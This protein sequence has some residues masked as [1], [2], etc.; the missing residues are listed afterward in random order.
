MKT[1]ILI[2]RQVFAI[3][4]LAVV[5]LSMNTGCSSSGDGDAVD[6]PATIPDVLNYEINQGAGI[7]LKLN[8]GGDAIVTSTRLTGTFNR[9]TQAFTL[10]VQS[11]AMSVS[12]DYFLTDL[13]TEL[14]NDIGEVVNFSDYSLHVK[15]ASTWIGNDNPTSGVFE[16]YDDAVRK[17]RVSVNGTTGVDII[18]WP[19]GE[20]FPSETIPT[21]AWGDFDGLY[22]DTNA[23]AYARVASF[24]FSMLRFMYEQGELVILALEFIGDNDTLIEQIGSIEESCDTYPF[25]PLP[26]PTVIPGMSRVSWS[27]ASHD[28]SLGAGDTF[29]LDF[30]E[31][32]DDDPNNDFDTL[33]NGTVN[34]VNYTE[35][36]SGGVLTR[37]GF[38]P[39]TVPGG[40]DF[41]SLKITETETTLSNVLIA[42]TETITLT[43]GF[44]MVFTSP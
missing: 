28:N 40:V 3:T 9:I 37:I 2:L 23:A 41:E 14:G 27:D 19:F 11:P 42:D 13:D 43:G 39:G 33:Y 25:A 4:A 44:S 1:P 10:N 38:E 21:V 17:I 36:Q 29:Y 6:I 24:A 32:W 20:G 18:Y 12:A 15:T 26:P 31:C 8:Q 22:D 30:T 16:I 5:M 35:V 34:F 7:L